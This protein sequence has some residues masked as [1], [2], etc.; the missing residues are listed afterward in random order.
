MKS[1]KYDDIIK[2]LESSNYLKGYIAAKRAL[3]KNQDIA[4]LTARGNKSDHDFLIKKLEKQLNTHIPRDMVFFVNDSNL[5]FPANVKKN[6]K[7]KMYIL[8]KLLKDYD[9]VK[10][11]DDEAKNVDY[12][13]RFA[14]LFKLQDK[15]K[16]YN[17]KNYD[18]S[19]LRPIKDQKD[20]IEKL[21]D[22]IIKE[23][24]IK[25]ITADNK[26]LLIDEVLKKSK[27]PRQMAE[28]IIHHY[29]LRRKPVIQV[30]DLDG[31]IWKLNANIYVKDKSGKERA[32][33]QEEFSK[34]KLKENETADFREFSDY[35][36]IIKT[37]KKDNIFAKT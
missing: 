18:V 15:L 9:K 22:D 5:Q 13:N 12:V 17:V 24:K 34:Y 4:I 8:L 27:M 3:L 35:S 6:H 14:K 28:T 37:I 23:K 21:I 20:R 29:A 31:T 19:K 32:M 7:R 25:K 1:K 11:H 2:V 36:E 16:A 10:F 26:D 30:F 33:S